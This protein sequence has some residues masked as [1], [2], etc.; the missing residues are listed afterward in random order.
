M[1]KIINVWLAFVFIC[2]FALSLQAQDTKPDKEKKEKKEKV[3]ESKEDSVKGGED[4][5]GKGKALGKE[6]EHKGKALGKEKNKDKKKE[7]N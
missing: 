1:K 7:D 5:K 3:K 2:G 4:K 6:K